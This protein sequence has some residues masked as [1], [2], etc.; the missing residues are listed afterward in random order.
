MKA[1]SRVVTIAT[2]CIQNWEH[3]EEH[4]GHNFCNACQKCVIDF[5]GYTNEAIL[6]VLTT[7]KTDVCG[8]LSQTQLDQLNFALIVAPSNRN[9]M[10]Y[11]GVL[12]IGTS[13][14]A[15]DVKGTPIKNKIEQININPKAPGKST[16]PKM[17]Y[18]YLFDIN[19]QPLNKIKVFISNTK[20]AAVTDINGRYEIKLDKTL[21]L[22]NSLLIVNNAIYHGEFEL[23]IL[24]EKQDN[25][26]LNK[27]DMMI[28]GEIRISPRKSKN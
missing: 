27:A 16:P 17:I 26:T 25:F 22:R 2:P 8:R 12:A 13:I 23:N 15:Q 5:T 28:L 24:E 9:W 19:H 11:L 1:K 14:F 10:K 7:S 21:N 20:L 18:G 6:Q 4:E 3:M